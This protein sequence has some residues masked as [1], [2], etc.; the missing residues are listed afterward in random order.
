[1]RPENHDA[2]SPADDPV[3]SLF[4]GRISGIADRPHPVLVAVSGGPD[5]VALA[6]LAAGVF[7]QAGRLSQ[8][9]VVHVN[10]GLRGA[11]SDA[12]AAFVGRMAAELGL[13]AVMECLQLPRKP[14]NP[15][16]E[17]E[18]RRAR[19]QK[20]IEAARRVGARTVLTGH[21]RDD[22]AE[23]VLFRIFRGTA[24]R[25]LKG[26]PAVRRLVDGITLVRPLLDS[27]RAA[28]LE[29][30]S[31][32][33]IPYRLDSSNGGLEPSRNWVRNQLIP[34]L[35]TRFDQQLAG[36]IV[37]LGEIAGEQIELLDRLA[38]EL[39]SRAET[40]SGNCEVCFDRARMSAA[41]PVVLRHL[42][43]MLWVRQGWPERE[44]SRQKWM[45]IS[46]CIGAEPAE[47]ASFDL[48]GFVH[49][50]TTRTAVLFR[51]VSGEFQNA[52]LQFP[53]AE[54]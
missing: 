20:L 10:H 25:G 15:G 52:G 30:L 44:M 41:D 32:R 48:P 35:Q 40:S 45:E 23:T 50:E 28:I 31:A 54:A 38:G 21:N 37:E 13:A 12:D 53:S 36:R 34:Q 39:C 46:R 49:F 18:C 4:A 24:L 1:M 11:E 14:G 51:S 47:T 7:Q 8:I 9:V 17:D 19:Y 29:Y 43:V 6:H 26:I 22:Q 2:V 3:E 16:R 27:S 33:Q 5:S 42:L